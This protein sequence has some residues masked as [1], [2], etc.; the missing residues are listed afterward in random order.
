M[1]FSTKTFNYKMFC[2]YTVICRET[3]RKNERKSRKTLK[4]IPWKMRY[5]YNQSSL[6]WCFNREPIKIGRFQ[7][8][9]RM[10]VSETVR[11]HD[12]WITITVHYHWDMS[13]CYSLTIPSDQCLK[14]DNKM[15][16][17][18]IKWWSDLH[19]QKSAANCALVQIYHITCFSKFDPN[20]RH[21]AIK[22]YTMYLGMPAEAIV[23][24]EVMQDYDRN[25]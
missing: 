16:E 20:E 22:R 2:S 4:K 6:T 13:I 24:Y 8:E 21:H 18:F 23:A 7:I 10:N 17:N 9:C 11:T 15:I 3:M 19:H 5:Y 12:T 1:E 25:T 14:P